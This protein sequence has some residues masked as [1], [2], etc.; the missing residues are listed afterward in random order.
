MT[1]F[2][3]NAVRIQPITEEAFIPFGH[4]FRPTGSNGRRNN[5]GV[6]Q[7]LRPGAPINLAQVEGDDRSQ[8]SEFELDT[9]ERHVF[10]S[11]SF[12]PQDVGRYLVVVCESG[13]GGLP[14]LDRLKA[15]SVPGDVGVSYLPG[16]WHAGISVL[17]GRRNF[18]MVVHED[19]SEADCE[20]LSVPPLRLLLE[21]VPANQ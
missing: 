9:L 5:F 18:L 7:N 6:I 17:Q 2:S 19:G 4:V 1:Q 3:P 21:P 11:Q 20:F 13:D 8:T 10:S 14:E 12:F 16:V 15:F